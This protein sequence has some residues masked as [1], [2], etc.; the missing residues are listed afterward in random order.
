VVNAA[1][2]VVVVGSRSVCGCSGGDRVGNIVA[3]W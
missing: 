2:V 1:A 3:R